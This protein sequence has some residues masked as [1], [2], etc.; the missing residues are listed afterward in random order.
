MMGLCSIAANGNRRQVICRNV[1]TFLSVACMIVM[2]SLDVYFESGDSVSSAV[3]PW[4][5]GE[6][7]IECPKHNETK[8]WAYS[9]GPLVFIFTIYSAVVVN[10]RLLG[11][12]CNYRDIFCPRCRRA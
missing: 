9:M 5:I 6:I 1:K 8:T 2:F 4:T 7:A 12:C 10:C 11:V 3:R